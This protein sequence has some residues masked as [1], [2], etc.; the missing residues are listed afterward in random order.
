MEN[1]YYTEQGEPEGF[2]NQPNDPAPSSG[3]ASAALILG[4]VS[5][6][7]SCCFYISIPLGA[8]A[9]LFAILSKDPSRPYLSQARSGLVLAIIG[10]GATVLLLI[11]AFVA[12]VTYLGDSELREQIEDYME[13]Y[14]HDSD[15]P[16]EGE[17]SDSFEY[18]RGYGDDGYGYNTP[19]DGYYFDYT[20][21]QEAPSTNLPEGSV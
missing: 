17:P 20:P 7:T 10:M 18:F 14:D 8:L 1:Q 16:Q 15:A 5:I 13:F 3:M 6:V 12:N 9:I 21:Y 2:E 4:I 11:L 19:G